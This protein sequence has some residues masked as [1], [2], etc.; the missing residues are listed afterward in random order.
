V[1]T[2]AGEAT[3]ARMAPGGKE[4]SGRRSGQKG[5][6]R[7][8]NPGGNGIVVG[9]CSDPAGSIFIGCAITDG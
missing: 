8:H 1:G 7:G 4:R 3:R 5:M 6:V 9:D 2:G